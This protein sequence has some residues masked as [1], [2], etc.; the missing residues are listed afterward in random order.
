MYLTAYKTV[1]KTDCG[2]RKGVGHANGLF[3]LGTDVTN[4]CTRYYGFSNLQNL[5]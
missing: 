5:I 4:Y 3:F 2:G 1:I